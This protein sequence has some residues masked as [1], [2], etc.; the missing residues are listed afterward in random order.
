MNNL[1]EE[2][3]SVIILSYKNF[4][5]IYEAIDSVFEQSY[6]SI[7]LIIADDCSENYPGELLQK[8]IQE[9]KRKNILSCC[10][11]SNSTNYGTVK[12]LNTAIKIS[13]GCEDTYNASTNEK[14]L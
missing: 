8:Y 2:T 4:D 1:P 14:L 11:Y 9:N 13:L 12:N 7:E 10:V 3:I 6:P 5:Y